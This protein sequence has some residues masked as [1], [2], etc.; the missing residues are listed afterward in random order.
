MSISS[1]I[2]SFNHLLKE[3]QARLIAVSKTKPNEDLLAAYEAGQRAFGETKYK[4]LAA[5][6]R[7]CQRTSSGI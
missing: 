1:N 4:N 7:N 6:L 5:S 2:E 3:T